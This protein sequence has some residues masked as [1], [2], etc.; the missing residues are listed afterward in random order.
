[1]GT[2]ARLLTQHGNRV[3]AIFYS[4]QAGPLRAI[5]ARG[6][7]LQVLREARLRFALPLVAIGGITPDNAAPLIEAGA[8][9]FLAGSARHQDGAVP[10][11][12]PRM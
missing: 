8:D 12:Q 1:M 3:G 10:E 5:P 2:L 4:G 9:A 11:L 6:G 7:R